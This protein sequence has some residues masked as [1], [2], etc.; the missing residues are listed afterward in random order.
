[1]AGKTVFE[2]INNITAFDLA[3]VLKEYTPEE[4]KNM[5]LLSDYRGAIRITAD[6]ELEMLNIEGGYYLG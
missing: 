5:D 6:K 3:Q 1:M 4:L 2:T